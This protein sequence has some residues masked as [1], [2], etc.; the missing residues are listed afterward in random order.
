[1]QPRPTGTNRATYHTYSDESLLALIE[2]QDVAAYEQ[3]YDRHAQTIYGLILRIVRSQTIAEEVLQEVF[4]QIWK[5]AG[6]FKNR[7]AAKAWIF[8]IARNRSL[9]EL[10]RQK[11]RP[12]TAEKIEVETVIHNAGSHHQS[13]AQEAER[14]HNA[15]RIQHALRNIPE[16]Q[17]TCFE[18][19]YF[20]G[21]SQ[22]EIAKE[23][24]IPVGTVK[25]RMRIGLEKLE[26][27]LRSEGFP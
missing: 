24:N 5:N 4:W 25:S 1:M 21:L 17:R 9:D 12:Q 18:L 19:A 20:E 7:G 14:Q 10:R 13:A 8:R 11:V 2:E 22:R 23:I 15:E 3:L 26:R 6:K 27:L 16:E